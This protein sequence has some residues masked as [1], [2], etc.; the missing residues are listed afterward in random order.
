MSKILTVFMNQMEKVLELENLDEYHIKYR[1][2]KHGHYPL[3]V[4]VRKQ[5]RAMSPI[6]P[7]A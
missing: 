2:Y 7:R 4:P 5:D 1:G 3:I 6:V